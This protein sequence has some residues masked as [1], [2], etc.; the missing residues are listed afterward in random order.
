MS[1]EKEYISTRL[2]FEKMI[3]QGAAVSTDQLLRAMEIVERQID[4]A[5]AAEKKVLCAR[6]DRLALVIG[7]RASYPLV[8]YSGG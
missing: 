2:G 5:P 6:L 3:C 1:I 8:M 4:K 7:C